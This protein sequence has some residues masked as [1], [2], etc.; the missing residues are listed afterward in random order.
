MAMVL[1]EEQAQ[2][3][4]AAK[5][6][7]QQ[8]APVAALRKLRDDNDETGFSRGL[9]QQMVD[10][11][12]AGILI[13]EE[14]GGLELT[15]L[16]MGL[17][18][19]EAGRGLSASPLLSTGILGA[20]LIQQAGTTEQK[21][22]LL[23]A[24]ASGELLTAL[25]LDEG[26]HHRPNHIT[27]TAEEA[28]NSYK[29]NG[30][31]VMV[32]DGHIADKLIVVAR[33]AD[34]IDDQSGISLFLVDANASGVTRSRNS[35]VDS[36]NT[37]H[38]QLD[39]VTAEAVLGEVGE[40]FS[41]LEQVLDTARIC[42]GAEMLGSC[43]EAFERVVEYLKTREQFGAL[44]GTFQGL[45][46]RAADMFCELELCKSAVREG[47]TSLDEERDDTPRLASLAKA[48][49]NDTAKLVSNE[50][51][52]MFGGIGMTDEE[53]IGFFLKRARVTMQLLG[54]TNYHLDRYAT[55]KGF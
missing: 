47:L 6:F 9:W 13:K 54:D 29:L 4:D 21:A 1:T 35:M 32:L 43:S 22:D 42:L 24:I 31:K 37:A 38:I 10:L 20:G 27:T 36:R 49:L 15:P 11:G 40:G 30:H 23:P 16:W 28:G 39:N 8:N 26:N 5:K 48:Q 46:H 45:Q 52:Q 50:T 3:Q 2:L 19:E 41:P 7:L 44:I 25:A 18:M 33:T 14:F 55:L 51:V 17:V 34:N 53:E 12:W